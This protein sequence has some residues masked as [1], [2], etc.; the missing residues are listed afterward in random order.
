MGA[1]IQSTK[2]TVALTKKYP[3]IYGAVGVHPSDAG[4]M[5]EEVL[6]WLKSLTDLDKI[7]AV[8]EIGLDYYWDKEEDVRENQ[9]RW[10][11][12]SSFRWPGSVAFR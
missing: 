8:G 12:P 6:A 7:A 11:I 10:F 3:F 1:N 5:N 2:S 4:E 9:K